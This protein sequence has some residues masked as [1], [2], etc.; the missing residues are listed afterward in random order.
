[1]LD[2]IEKLLIG[3]IVTVYISGLVLCALWILDMNL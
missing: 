1:M 3:V 2:R